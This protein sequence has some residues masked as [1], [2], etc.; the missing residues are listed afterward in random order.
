MSAIVSGSKRRRSAD[1]TIDILV[2]L[3]PR[4]YLLPVGWSGMGIGRWLTRQSGRQD[5]IGAR[6]TRPL[7]CLR[8]RRKISGTVRAPVGAASRPLEPGLSRKPGLIFTQ[9]SPQGRSTPG[10]IGVREDVPVGLYLLILWPYRQGM[11]S[12]RPGFAARDASCLSVLRRSCP[13][14]S[15]DARPIPAFTGFCSARAL[16]VNAL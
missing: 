9:Q 2:P 15:V 8:T 5:A 3:N 6:R 11:A 1:A 13:A 14:L 12:G 10:Q 4:A 16:R 7:R